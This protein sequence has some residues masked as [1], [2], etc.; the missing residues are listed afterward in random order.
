MYLIIKFVHL[1]LIAM[2]R[3]WGIALSLTSTSLSCS[4]KSA[5]QSFQ[6]CWKYPHVLWRPKCDGFCPWP[7]SQYLWTSKIWSQISPLRIPP[8]RLLSCS[9]C[10]V[11]EM[12]ARCW[13]MCLINVYFRLSTRNH[14]YLKS[15]NY[16]FFYKRSDV[17]F[18]CSRSYLIS[19]LRTLQSPW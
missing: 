4:G 6:L 15:W 5:I 2:I 9:A 3:N 17:V 16:H 8:V 18:K 1:T 12:G 7:S 10:T 13:L 19:N 14:R 11:W